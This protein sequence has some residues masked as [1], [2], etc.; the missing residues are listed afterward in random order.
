MGYQQG[1]PP[2]AE[3]GQVPLLAA[4]MAEADKTQFQWVLKQEQCP[5]KAGASYL[6]GKQVH[7]LLKAETKGTQE[8]CPVK[9][10]EQSSFAKEEPGA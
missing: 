10:R 5:P 4:V 6:H 2:L 8:S 9:P 1:L 7:R 3:L